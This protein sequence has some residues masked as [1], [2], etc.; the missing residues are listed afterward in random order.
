MSNGPRS[1]GLRFTSMFR[2]R[3]GPKLERRS[4]APDPAQPAEP[5]ERAPDSG[6]ERNDDDKPPTPRA[7]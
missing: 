7:A 6:A 1:S 5:T 3:R 4:P 2:S